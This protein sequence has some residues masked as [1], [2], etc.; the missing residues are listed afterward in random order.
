MEIKKTNF[1]VIL[2]AFYEVHYEDQIQLVQIYHLVITVI[3]VSFM[4]SISKS[5]FIRIR[6]VFSYI[7]DSEGLISYY[8]D[9]CF[10]NNAVSE[11][12]KPQ[13]VRCS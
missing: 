7:E 13:S 10:N 9:T 11:D 6:H 12:F 1:T 8:S 2:Q 5:S 3:T 4:F